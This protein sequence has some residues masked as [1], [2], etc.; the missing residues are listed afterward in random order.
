VDIKLPGGC[1]ERVAYDGPSGFIYLCYYEVD[2]SIKW[3]IWNTDETN[4]VQKYYGS[5]SDVKVPD[6]SKKE[7]FGGGL[8]RVIPTG[9]DKYSIIMG[10]FFAKPSI[11]KNLYTVP[12]NI[13][14]YFINEEAVINGPVSIYENTN[15]NT[16]LFQIQV[17]NP[18]AGSIGNFKCLFSLK[19]DEASP[20]TKFVSVLFSGSG[21]VLSTFEFDVNYEKTP[22]TL[23]L[24][25][26][27]WCIGV[28]TGAGLNCLAY[29]EDG[30]F[31]E[32]WGIPVNGAPNGVGALSNNIMWA[33]PPFESATSWTIAY[34]S[35]LV[36]FIGLPQS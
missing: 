11:D 25:A 29:D 3:E 1:S 23:S 14:T 28:I 24:P 16:I 20:S 17:C 32:D 7:S 10:T 35:K 22:A 6:K 15:G 12:V 33:I 8:F 18:E 4:F 5:I 34:S 21:E 30:V 2:K 9:E 26:G 27:G 36:K 31:H 13:Y 19:Y